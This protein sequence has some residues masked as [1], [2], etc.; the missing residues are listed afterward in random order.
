MRSADDVS[1]AWSPLSLAPRTTPGPIDSPASAAPTPS[2]LSSTDHE[3]DVILRLD[4]T[5]AK[6]VAPLRSSMKMRQNRFQKTIR[7]MPTLDAEL[8]AGPRAETCVR[9]DCTPH[10]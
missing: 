7:W 9:Q 6:L 8:S 3:A 10:R 2:S 5:A 4:S 1:A